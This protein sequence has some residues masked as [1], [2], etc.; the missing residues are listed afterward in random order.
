[1]K[2]TSPI[3][4]DVFFTGDI[5]TDI[6]TDGHRNSM[7]E[8]AKWADSV[9]KTYPKNPRISTYVNKKIKKIKWLSRLNELDLCFFLF[10]FF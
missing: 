4:G 1:M 6:Q 10:W 8:S 7:T 2:K 3:Q 5:N 9:K